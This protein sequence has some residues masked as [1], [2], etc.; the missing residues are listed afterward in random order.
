MFPFSAVSQFL[1]TTVNSL[2]LASVRAIYS[3]TRDAIPRVENHLLLSLLSVTVP[4]RLR[5]YP[6]GSLM[7]GRND[8]YCHYI[9]CQ[10]V[11]S[12]LRILTNICKLG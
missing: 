2:Q 11:T 5:R 10:S 6:P 12:L 3:I 7:Q 9:Q 8:F 4:D 1:K